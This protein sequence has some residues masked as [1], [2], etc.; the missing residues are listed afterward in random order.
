MKIS[1]VLRIAVLVAASTVFLESRADEEQCPPIQTV[2]SPDL[3]YRYEGQTEPDKIPDHLKYRMFVGTYNVYLDE[4]VQNLSRRDHAILSNLKVDADNWRI[5][6]SEQYGRDF[7]NLCTSSSNMDAVEYAQEYERIAAQSNNRY[8]ERV[9][10]AFNLLSSDGRQ[11]VENY[12]AEKI[13]PELSH[14]IKTGVDYA[15]EDPE[16]TLFEREFMCYMQINGEHPPEVAR[17]IECSRRQ[18][19]AESDN[20]GFNRPDADRQ[21][22]DRASLSP[23]PEN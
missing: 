13:T 17:F 23:D 4:L 7:L 14:P 10:K 1:K 3:Y 9:R 15:L 12:I 11:L 21:N 22:Q 18:F 2:E 8:V 16:Q 20:D 5:A 6:D 19:E